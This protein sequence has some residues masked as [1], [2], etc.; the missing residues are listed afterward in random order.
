MAG[1]S[2]KCEVHCAVSDDGAAR[3][4]ADGQICR[5][6]RHRGRASSARLPDR[7]PGS[8]DD[9]R[10]HDRCVLDDA[11]LRIT[12]VVDTG[13]DGR[14]TWTLKIEGSLTGEWLPELRR[15]W[16]RARETVPGG[17]IRVHLADVRF[18]DAAAKTLLADMY[19]A[20]VDIV[21]RG[22]MAVDVRDDI[23]RRAAAD[24]RA[25]EP[26]RGQ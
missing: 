3:V 14:A 20:G 18:V 21:A 10:R 23:V 16:R 11:M 26:T 4:S 7:V 15:A 9:G 24:R 1:D 19:R 6:H 25:G 2:R 12:D 8:R 13:S 22:L 5:A 17:E